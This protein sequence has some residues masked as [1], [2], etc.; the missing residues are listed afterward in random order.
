MSTLLTASSVTILLF[1]ISLILLTLFVLIAFIGHI[2]NIVRILVSSILVTIF[3]VEFLLLFSLGFISSFSCCCH[4]FRIFNSIMFSILNQVFNVINFLAMFIIFGIGI[5]LIIENSTF[6][7]TFGIF[8]IIAAPIMI[9]LFCIIFISSSFVGILDAYVINK[10]KD[11]LIVKPIYQYVNISS[12]VFCLSM[13]VFLIFGTGLFLICGSIGGIIIYVYTAFSTYVM[14]EPVFAASLLFL[15]SFIGL[16]FICLGAQGFGSAIS[17]FLPSLKAVNSIIFSFLNI[18][19]F[20]S[21]SIIFATC[22]TVFILWAGNSQ[23]DTPRGDYYY[24]Y[25]FLLFIPVLGFINFICCSF[26]IADSITIYIKM[27]K[28]NGEIGKKDE[29]MENEMNVNKEE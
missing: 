1:G 22:L 13:F 23:N 20:I 16:T 7:Y 9:I 2:N 18:V 12:I 4:K 3:I 26:G 27:K 8:L 5:V 15:F 21:N 29:N 24:C 6:E 19:Y 25:L 11:N 28:N 14:V 10:I 17:C